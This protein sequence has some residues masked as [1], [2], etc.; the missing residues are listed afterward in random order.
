MYIFNIFLVAH[1]F[2]N[3]LKTLNGD[4]YLFADNTTLALQDKNISNLQDKMQETQSNAEKWFAANKLSLNNNKTK[5]M[6]FS[7]KDLGNYD[8][9]SQIKFLGITLDPK[10]T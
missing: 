10:L 7:Y 2:I 1:I 4:T 8:N 3:N 5:H 9:I 6:I